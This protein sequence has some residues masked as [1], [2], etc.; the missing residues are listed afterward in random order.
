MIYSGHSGNSSV[1]KKTPFVTGY[2]ATLTHDTQ[3]ENQ[4]YSEAGPIRRDG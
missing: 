1:N 2:P 4:G 3:Y